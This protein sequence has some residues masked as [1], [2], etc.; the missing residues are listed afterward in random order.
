MK[1]FSEL[2]HQAQQRK[3]GKAGLQ[4]L[5]TPI[6]PKD[7]LLSLGDDRFLST[8]AKVINQAGF[9]WSVVEKK[10]PQ[11]EAAFFDF[12]LNVLSRLPPEKWEEYMLDTRIVR[13]WQKIKAVMD[14][15]AFVYEVSQD[16]GS[17]AQ[18]LAQWPDDDQVGLMTYLKKNGSRLGGNTGQR[19][20]RYVGKD[21]F[22][23]TGDVVL[24]LQNADVDIANNVTS[25]RDLRKV[26]NAFNGW[27]QEMGLP[28]THLSKIA[29]FSTGI[30]YEMSSED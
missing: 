5:L 11:F 19:F 30:N 24:A 20:L 6:P 23:L 12:N 8:M 18:F 25:Q 13:H 21:A 16:H 3:G 1:K 28:Y 26:Q 9:R 10:W 7:Y 17:F 2:L 15:V 4:Q 22:M 14:N 29:A 27:R